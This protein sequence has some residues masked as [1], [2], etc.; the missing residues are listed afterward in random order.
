MRKSNRNQ[1]FVKD[2]LHCFTVGVSCRGSPTK[3]MIKRPLTK[4]WSKVKVNDLVEHLYCGRL[5]QFRK[6]K[7]KRP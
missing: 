3:T 6:D 7:D 4:Q 2:G 1:F 5:L